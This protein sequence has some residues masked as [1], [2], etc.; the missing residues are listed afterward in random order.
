MNRTTKSVLAVTC[1]SHLSVH[2]LMLVLPS[3]LLVM[4][5]E[6]NVGLGT[7]GMVVAASSFAFGAGALPAGLLESRVG[8][9][10]LLLI[11][12]FGTVASV[13]LIVLSQSLALFTT[14][15]VML[16]A[17]SSLYHPAGLTLISRRVSN[18]SKSL[19]IHGVAGTSGLALGPIIAA[20]FT[21]LVSWRMA[22][23]VLAVFNLLLAFATL[24]L[25]PSRKSN[26]EIEKDAQNTTSTN[27]PALINYYM[28]IVLVGLAFTG[29]TTY[30]PAYFTNTTVNLSAKLS[31]TLR[32]GLFT[33]IVLLGGVVGQLIG[34]I[35]GDRFQRTRLMMVIL[36]LN[37]PLLLLIGYTTELLLVII[38]VI[39]GIV[40][41]SHQPVGNALIANFTHSHSRGIGYGINFFLSFGIG[42]IAAAVG[43]FIAEHYGLNLV[44][45]VMGIIMLPAV[46]IAYRLVKLVDL[47]KKK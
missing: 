21:E 16:G 42:S 19:G 28:I 5:S 47:N 43:G 20:S 9:R 1:G 2:S 27:R 11:Y 23:G 45:P 34:G 17:F 35:L 7:L 38:A 4:Q 15:V 6:F 32:G 37:I 40:H 36:I 14:G 18:L 22:Y 41:F 31:D 44:F 30:M 33:T 13:F 3:I 46:F 10:K 24:V 12:Q 8:G 29:F 39:F 26:P 25:I